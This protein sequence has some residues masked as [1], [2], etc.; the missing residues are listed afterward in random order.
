MV[1]LSWAVI[2]DLQDDSVEKASQAWNDHVRKISE[3]WEYSQKVALKCG[4]S[5]VHV[6]DK[7]VPG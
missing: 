6:G 7:Y 1:Q 3:S 4:W 5:K 2:C